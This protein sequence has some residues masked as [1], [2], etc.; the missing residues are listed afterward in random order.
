MIDT[1]C[2]MTEMIRPTGDWLLGCVAVSAFREHPLHSP[3]QPNPALGIN[4]HQYT[5]PGCPRILF[6]GLGAGRGSLANL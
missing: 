1:E 3:Q 4:C 2:A 5:H 6:L